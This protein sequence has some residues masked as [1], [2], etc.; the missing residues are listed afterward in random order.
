MRKLII[1][2]FTFFNLISPIYELQSDLTIIEV[3]VWHSVYLDTCQI[4]PE[5]NLAQISSE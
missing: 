4:C 3:V 5:G 2:F 1:I